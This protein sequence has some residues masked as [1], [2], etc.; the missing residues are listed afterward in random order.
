ME[1]PLQLDPRATAL[2]VVDMQNDFCRPDG[3][4]AGAG[5]KTETLEALVPNLSQLV[6]AMRHSGASIV[7]T[8]IVHDPAIPDVHE[9]HAIL[10]GGW[11]ATGTRLLPGTLGAEIVA[12]LRPLPGD[13]VVDKSGYSAFADTSLG[14]QLRRRGVKAVAL[15]GA[16]DYACVLHTAFDAFELDFDVLLVDDCTAGWDPALAGAARRIVHLLLGQ[17]LLSEAV[18]EAARSGARGDPTA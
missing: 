18:V 6:S 9:R 3:Y 17:V 13:I 1:G 8:R 2:V 15:A 11:R 16:V 10:P 7:F 14:P 4:F 12:E 5:F